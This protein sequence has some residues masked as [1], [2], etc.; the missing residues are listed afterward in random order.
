MSKYSA[1]PG[2]IYGP[3]PLRMILDD[4]AAVGLILV[5]DGMAAYIWDPR[6]EGVIWTREFWVHPEKRRQGIATRLFHEIASLPGAVIIMSVTSIR[7]PEIN[8][9]YHKIGRNL[10]EQDGELMYWRDEC[11]EILRK[12]RRE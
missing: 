9:T 7:N 1:P 12:S 8:Q 3:R 6:E 2:H 10:V 5:E 4:Y 11:R